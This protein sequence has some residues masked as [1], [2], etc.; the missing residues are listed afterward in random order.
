MLTMHYGKGEFL[1]RLKILTVLA[2][3]GQEFCFSY[4]RS[5]SLKR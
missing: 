5:A 2:L 4:Q 3:L 1:A